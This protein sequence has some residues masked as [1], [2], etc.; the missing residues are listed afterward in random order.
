MIP[1]FKPGTRTYILS[2]VALVS[3]L[4]LQAHAQGVLALAPMIKLTL[5]LILTAVTPLVPIYIRKAFAAMEA[6]KSKP[7]ISR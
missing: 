4:L 3:A 7:K 1:F 2:G 6:G 5:V